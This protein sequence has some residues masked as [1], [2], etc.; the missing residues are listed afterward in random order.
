MTLLAKIA[1]L[2]KIY[3]FA[4]A[5]ISAD[6]NNFLVVVALEEEIIGTCHLTLLPSLT[7]QASKRMNIEAVRVKNN[8]RS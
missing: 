3:E 6:K 8:F 4:F 5:E 1:N 2:R 7:L